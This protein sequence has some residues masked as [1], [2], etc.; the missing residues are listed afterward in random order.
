MKL[1][2]INKL[3]ANGPILVAV[4]A[5]ADKGSAVCAWL[6]GTGWERVGGRH[7]RRFVNSGN[8]V[9]IGTA[10]FHPDGLEP[11]VV[12]PSNI[13]GTWEDWKKFAKEKK[14]K[15]QEEYRRKM[16]IRD[17]QEQMKAEIIQKLETGKKC[18]ETTG[19]FKPTAMVI[20]L[21]SKEIDLILRTLR[22]Y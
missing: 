9:A 18:F 7:S 22:G 8:G 5:P 14:E 13:W 21:T 15:E 4:K 10:L 2:A 19:I 12:P 6:V 16:E 1:D 17:H 20:S 11:D 3:L